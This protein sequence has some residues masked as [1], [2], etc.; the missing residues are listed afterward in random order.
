MGMEQ[1]SQILSLRQYFGW[2]GPM[3]VFLLVV[4]GRL[5]YAASFAGETIIILVIG[6]TFGILTLAAIPIHFLNHR[7][8]IG[9]VIIFTTMIFITIFLFWLTSIAMAFYLMLAVSLYTETWSVRCCLILWRSRR[10]SRAPISMET[11]S[12]NNHPI[13]PTLTHSQ[14][15][16]ILILGSFIG[17]AACF[18]T[19]PL[20]AFPR[21]QEFLI[22]DIQAQSYDLVLYYP[23]AHRINI[24]VCAIAQKYNVTLS[25]PI[26]ESQFSPNHKD[27]NA[28]VNAV[29]LCNQYG[30]SVEMWPLFDWN[31]GSYPSFSEVDRVPGLYN[32]FHTW[33]VIHGLTVQYLLWDIEA[34]GE[35]DPC[36]KEYSWTENFGPFG[37]VGHAQYCQ[38]TS[39]E[40][41]D[42]AVNVWGEVN[43][44]ATLDGHLVR[45]TTHWQIVYDIFD[46]DD[47][48]QRNWRLPVWAA[49]SYQY[50]STM[51]YRG[52]DGPGDGPSAMIYEGIRAAANKNPGNVAV[53]L[54][55][56]NYE[57]YPDIPS[58]IADVHLSLAA[59]ATSIRLFQ[60]LSWVDGTG[61][62]AGE[63]DNLKWTNPPHNIDGL[64]A[65]LEACR[66]GGVVTY[67]PDSRLKYEIFL[68]LLMDVF[69]DFV[70]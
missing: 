58:V 24:T 18:L 51:S 33:T 15:K 8:M 37:Y 12:L 2:I 47:N 44:Q 64:D 55:C 46:D 20:Y 66:K 17:T 52:C 14:K 28:Y 25:F 5:F 67:H 27:Y 40:A 39:A 23:D 30:V 21:D 49:G 32:T 6:T 13:F 1:N 61:E 10:S 70:L 9:F 35:Y 36:S 31:N 4:C 68:N 16:A 42:H 54:G 38:R 45:A 60:G 3:V 7:R 19:V 57:P 62:K 48:L 26:T 63:P 43:R 56:I 59:G 50:V 34:G 29:R 53:C 41:W 22:S 65:L 11:N 69:S